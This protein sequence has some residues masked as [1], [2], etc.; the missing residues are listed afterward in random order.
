MRVARCEMSEPG[1][2]GVPPLLAKSDCLMTEKSRAIGI[3]LH[4]LK[5]EVTVNGQKFSAEMPQLGLSDRQIAGAL[6]FVRNSF[7][8][9]GEMVSVA[10]VATAR[11]GSKSQTGPMVA[12]E[13]TKGQGGPPGR[14]CFRARPRAPAC[15]WPP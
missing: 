15:C 9:K 6:T 2:G 13:I 3:L 8:N 1:T 10:E 12:A 7:G 11:A 5:G 4:A 14:K